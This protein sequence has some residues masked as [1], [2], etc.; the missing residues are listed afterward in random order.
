MLNP[1]PFRPITYCAAVLT[2]LFALLLLSTSHGRAETPDCFG[3]LL[4]RWNEFA[5]NANNHIQTND[6]KRANHEKAHGKLDREWEALHALSC[7]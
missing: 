4:L 7:W 5:S 2:L 6:V 3:E 1:W